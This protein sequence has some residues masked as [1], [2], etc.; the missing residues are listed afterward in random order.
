MPSNICEQC[1]HRHNAAHQCPNY[2]LRCNRWVRAN[3]GVALPPVPV[4]ELSGISVVCPHC[5]SRSWRGEDMNC[6][7]NGRLQLPLE[8]DVPAE[9]QQVILSAHVRQHIRR[10]GLIVAAAL[11]LFLRTLG[12]ILRLRWR[13][14]AMIIDLFQIP[15]LLWVAARITVLVVFVLVT[16]VM[17]RALLKFTCWMRMNRPNVGV[18]L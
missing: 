7:G 13:P 15:L 9:V 14:W 12:T 16:Q 1:G 6:C 5:R 17:L 4:H 11:P 2:R 3:E 18:T 8:D 10:Y